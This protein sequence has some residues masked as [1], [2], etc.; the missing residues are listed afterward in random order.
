MLHRKQKL[1]QEARKSLT[2]NSTKKMVNVG[3]RCFFINIYYHKET[4]GQHT[5]STESLTFCKER[6]TWN[7]V[8]SA[9]ICVQFT[10]ILPF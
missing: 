4:A 10:A 8:I 3:L 2:G 6:C 1:G 9:Q 7:D 5:T